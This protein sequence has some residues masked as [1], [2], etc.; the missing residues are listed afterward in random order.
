MWLT[1]DGVVH[2]VAVPDPG[3]VVALHRA[4]G[5]PPSTA[6]V[7]ALAEARDELELLFFAE[8]AATDTDPAAEQ[9]FAEAVPPLLT[10]TLH[11]STPADRAG[12][13]TRQLAEEPVRWRLDWL[14]AVDDLLEALG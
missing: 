5:A 1:G 6:D 8:V 9:P 7:A 3:T 10:I 11:G 13:F 4:D 12:S 14:L 2:T